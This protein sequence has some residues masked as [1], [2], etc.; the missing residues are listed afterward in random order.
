MTETAEAKG[1]MGINLS[2]VCSECRGPLTVVK[3]TDGSPWWEIRVALCRVCLCRACAN[4][5]KSE[6]K[7]E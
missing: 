4:A 2:I 7:G 3:G 5:A 6:P 1:W